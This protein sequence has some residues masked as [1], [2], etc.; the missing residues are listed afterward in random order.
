M[1]RHAKTER[2]LLHYNGH[3]VPRPTDNG[4]LWVFD[5]NHTQYIPLSVQELRSW[6]GTPTIVVLDCSNAGVLLP[7]FT[8]SFVGAGAATAQGSQGQVPLCSSSAP[9]GVQTGGYVSPYMTSQMHYSA[10]PSSIAAPIGD[11]NGNNQLRQQQQHSQYVQQKSFI[12]GVNV[13]I[14]NQRDHQM[15]NPGMSPRAFS[16]DRTASSIA[17]VNTPTPLPQDCIVLCP[18]AEGELLPVNPE[19]PADIF[20]SCLTTPIPIALRWFVRQNPLS[21]EGVDPESV[22]RIPGKISDRKT[23]LGELNWIFTAVTDTIAWNV[24]PSSLFQRLFRQDL[25]VASMFRNFLLADRILRSLNCTPTSFPSLPST[26][27]HPLWQ[28]WDL[29]VESCLYQLMRDGH[30]GVDMPV[31]SVTMHAKD[32]KKSADFLDNISMHSAKRKSPKAV[33]VDVQFFSEQLTAFEVWLDFAGMHSGGGRS[34]PQLDPPEQLPVV[35][36]VLL[37]QAHRVRALVL[38]KRFL[39]LGPWAVNLALSVGIFPYVLKLLQSPID[40]YK[41]VLV[42][43]WAKILSFD[44]SCQSDLVKDQ[45]LPHFINHL[46]WGLGNTGEKRSERLIGESRYG[47][48]LRPEDDAAEQRTMATFILSV[49]CLNFETGQNECR[50]LSLHLKCGELLGLMQTNNIDVCEQNQMWLCI[51]LGRMCEGNAQSQRD[52]YA[53]NIHIRLFACLGDKCPAV[54]AAAAYALGLFIGLP[55]SND[56]ASCNSVPASSRRSFASAP[57]NPPPR[58]YQQQQGYSIAHMPELTNDLRTRSRDYP[59]IYEDRHIIQSDILAVQK[60]SE[61]FGDASPSVRCELCLAIGCAVKKYLSAFSAIAHQMSRSCDSESSLTTSN[62]HMPLAFDEEKAV[63]LRSVWGKL[64]DLRQHDAHPKVSSVANSVVC[65]VN[66]HIFG[67]EQENSQQSMKGS[68]SVRS[69][70]GSTTGSLDQTVEKSQNMPSNEKDDVSRASLRRNVSEYF[71]WRAATS[72]DN[73]E[74]GSMVDTVSKSTNTLDTDQRWRG[75]SQEMDK[76]AMFIDGYFKQLSTIPKSSFGAKKHSEFV[77]ENNFSTVLENDPLSEIGAARVYRMRRNTQ[78]HNHG[79]KLSKEFEVLWPKILEQNK[80]KSD[81]HD[82]F[83]S[84]SSPSPAAAGMEALVL[85]KKKDLHMK[86]CALLSSDGVATMTSL[87]NF[88]PYEPVLAVCDGESCVSIWDYDDSV[89]ELSFHNGNSKSSRMTSMKW[90]NEQSESLLMTASDD[91]NIRIWDKVLQSDGSINAA[92]CILASAFCAAP[93]IQSVVEGK[94]GSGIVTEW[95]QYNGHLVVAGSSPSI[96]WF[97]LTTQQCVSKQNSKIGSCVTTLTTAWDALSCTP[98]DI[99]C[100]GIGPSI[101]VAGY[102]DGSMKV[103]D[104]RTNSNSGPSLK[105]SQNNRRNRRMTNYSEHSSWIVNTFFTGFGG[106]WEIMSG[107]VAGDVKFWDLRSPFR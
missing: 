27:N 48:R 100:S 3:G 57:A 96:R 9:R 83:K 41:H 98:N 76:N 64:I 87:L 58:Q 63:T 46:T 66:E 67:I 28:S 60:L 42:G 52:C 21:M 71:S 94:Q 19:F 29:A 93:D 49:I 33:N 79:S 26:A 5:K 25:L 8:S 47:H 44:S 16:S 77:E 81:S 38:L 23:P 102:G 105:T 90:I 6:I 40:E 106:N 24:L 70:M 2:L 10:I 91:G 17:S 14:G 62:F 61:A 53:K 4:E 80:P 50:R 51:C 37:S 107:C 45:A 68:H 99:G 30:L 104:C 54:R 97:D 101:V 88:H 59:M 55:S 82:N 31:R 36:Q 18:C 85:S 74:A 86:Q 56:E 69:V 89:K 39:D 92:G 35:L 65:Y 22:D 34:E 15:G 7:A 11:G 103:F 32:E 78:Y 84:E 73:K 72:A 20:T 12:P 13:N 1:R 75:P 43:I 95:Q